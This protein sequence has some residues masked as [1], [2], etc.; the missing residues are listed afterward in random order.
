MWQAN[1]EVEM[2]AAVFIGSLW[3]FGGGRDVGKAEKASE[4]E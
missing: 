4:D 1:H 2:E 3:W